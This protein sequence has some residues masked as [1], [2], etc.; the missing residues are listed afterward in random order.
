MTLARLWAFLAVALPVL[1]ALLAG[2]S[3]VDL[4]YHLRAGEQLLATGAIPT[5]DSFTFTAAGAPWLNQQW[6]AQAVLAVTFRIAGWTGLAVLR[7]ALVGVV[8]GCLFATCRRQ[9][10]DLRRA[11]W[12]TLAAFAVAAPAFALRP[13]LFG[14]ALLAVT[15]LIVSVR[16]AHPRAL[17]AV[18]IVVLVWANVHGS[19]FLGPLVLGLAWLADLHDRAPRRHL[20]LVV[21]AVS[22]AAALVNPFGLAVWSYAAGLSTNAVVTNRI[23]EWQPTTLR[24]VVGI[25]FFASVA[26][27][28]VVL[29]RRSRAVTWPTLAWLGLFAAIGAY[30]VRGV[31][32][33]P[34]GAAVALAALLAAPAGDPER[35]PRPERSSP[36]NVAVAAV[37]V[38]AGVA[39][40]PVW[41]AVDPRTGLPTGVVT[42]APPGI[43][44]ALRD[45]ALPSDRVYN[46]QPWGSWFEL[47]APV[48]PVAIDSRIELFPVAVWDD[49][50]RIASGGT[51][52]E[53]TMGKWGVTIVVADRDQPALVT[54]L[55]DRG[56]RQAFSDADGTILVAPAR[57]AEAAV[58]LAAA[59]QGLRS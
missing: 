27:V 9:G 56:W 43:T 38:L 51:G 16:R 55:T 32:W 57:S 19:F 50:D 14:M 26:L 4:A 52:W 13:Q 33:W 30:A 35:P 1:A 18:P 21:A 48:A 54:R 53:A 40:L 10:L 12:L 41:R 34:L 11:A 7:A 47:A 29:V 23:S 8:F 24:T 5:T 20:A 22:A 37:L 6:A 46:P 44:A 17:W 36:L 31:A 3:S 25:V 49:Y 45:L 42:D 15:L 39:L 2:L 28:V 59:L 58:G